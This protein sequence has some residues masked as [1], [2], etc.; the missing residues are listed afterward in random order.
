LT[1][2]GFCFIMLVMSHRK[3]PIV[4]DQVY[5]VFNRSIGRVPIFTENRDYQRA[6]NVLT[7]Y[8]Y[9]NPS[10]RFSHYNRL[11]QLQKVGFMDGLKQKADKQIELFAFCFMPNHIHFLIKEIREKGI[12]TFM[13]NFQNSYAKY[14]NTKENRSGGLFQQ[15]FKST[16]IE[17]DEQLIH[18][19]RYIH[20]NPVTA[21]IIKNF[22][23]L[24]LYPW[25]SYPTY[26]GKNS[27]DILNTEVILSHFKSLQRFI[28]FTQD[29]V[30]YQRKLDRI[31]HLILE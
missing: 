3:I 2:L 31:K 8:S 6:L 30:N 14:F 5:H 4:I 29:Q 24:V 28:E 17:A 23:D 26:V 21:F 13:S 15:M 16:L 20:L 1:P 7:F 18:V 11:P 25:S 27:S 19:A 22:K 10:L 12:T 9:H